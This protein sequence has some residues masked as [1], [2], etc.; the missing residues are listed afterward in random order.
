[1]ENGP[2]RRALGKGIIDLESGE[3]S[4]LASLDIFNN[5]KKVIEE[6]PKEQI[7]ELK[8]DELRSNPYQ[9]RKTFD[10]N[11]LNELAESIKENGV[12][13]PVIVRKAIKGYEIIAGE[14]R[15]KA[16]KMAGLET[17]PAI[18]RDL[19]DDQMALIALLENL[20]RENLNSI[21]EAL[22]YKKIMDSRGFTHEQLSKIVKKSQSYV[23]N[24]LGLLRLPDEI[25]DYVVDGKISSAHARILSKM[26]DKDTIINLANRVVDEK[27]SV[28]ELEEIA[29]GADIPKVVKRKTN[30]TTN[31]EFKYIEDVLC[32]K[33]D[34]KVRVFQNKI[35]IKYTNVDQLNKI[36]DILNR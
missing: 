26:S 31:T 18:I 1:M 3:F 20:Q 5:G 36:F 14:R 25:K 7:V 17:V 13:Q 2:R 22:A 29:R 8:I 9:P 34:T 16:S 28:R 30:K 19:N 12:F 33:L 4:D 11:A 27:L 32:E 15:C 21:E 35:E 23:T 10:E 24:M 6:T